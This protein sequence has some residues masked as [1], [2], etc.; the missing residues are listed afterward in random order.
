MENTC[1]W[2]PTCSLRRVSWCVCGVTWV[3]RLK[4]II[5]NQIE[6]GHL[7]HWSPDLFLCLLLPCPALSRCIHLAASDQAATHSL[8]TISI[9]GTILS[10]FYTVWDTTING[11]FSLDNP[12]S[13]NEEISRWKGYFLGSCILWISSNIATLD[14]R[15]ENIYVYLHHDVSRQQTGCGWLQQYRGQI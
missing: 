2:R 15:L 9:F 7:C 5:R 12:E 11:T 6:T 4:D 3:Q 14:L 13:N 10:R 8:A 1:W